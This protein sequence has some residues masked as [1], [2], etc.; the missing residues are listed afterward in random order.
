M[1][2]QEEYG[3]TALQGPGDRAWDGSA[4][5]KAAEWEGV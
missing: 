1:D 2:T 5:A 4:R 3:Q